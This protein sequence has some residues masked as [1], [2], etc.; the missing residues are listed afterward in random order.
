MPPCISGGSVAGATLPP[1]L[2]MLDEFAAL[3]R[4][5][6]IIKALGAARD[7]SIQLFM[8]A[9]L[10]ETVAKRESGP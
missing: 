2:F 10:I 1:V 3:G 7:Y 4:L 6:E 8:L 9:P 5:E